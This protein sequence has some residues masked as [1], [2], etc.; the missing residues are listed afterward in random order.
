MVG[1]VTPRNAHWASNVIIPA[2]TRP[3]PKRARMTTAHT[4]SAVRDATRYPVAPNPA[5]K[6]ANAGK[7][8]NADGLRE[9]FLFLRARSTP[10]NIEKTAS[11]SPPMN[12]ARKMTRNAV[13]I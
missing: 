11:T 12:A 9:R 7:L 5:A 3:P 1:P 10:C 8:K 2:I 4:G 13:T 6:A